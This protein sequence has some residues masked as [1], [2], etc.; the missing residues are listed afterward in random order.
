MSTFAS[1]THAYRRSEQAI[2]P[3][4]APPAPVP[5]RTTRERVER[6]WDALPFSATSQ[7]VLADPSMLDEAAYYGANVE[8]LI[9]VVRVPLGLAGPLRV[10]GRH[11]RGDYHV[12]LATDRGRPRRLL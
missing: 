1:L 8:N 10:D 4:P 7:A 3:A 11:A 2:N 9:G 6:R 12:P 5:A